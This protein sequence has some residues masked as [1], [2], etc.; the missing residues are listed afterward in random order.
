MS[1]RPEQLDTAAANGI[2]Y[3]RHV[4]LCTYPNCCT[5]EDGLAGELLK[6]QIKDPTWQGKGL[7]SHKVG[8]LRIRCHGPT[9]S[10]TPMERGITA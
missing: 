9:C 8:C 7:L 6:Q 2:A 5:P 1:E 4:L 10:F 3:R